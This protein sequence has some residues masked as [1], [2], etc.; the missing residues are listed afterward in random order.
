MNEPTL[1]D[2]PA[3]VGEI[4]AGRAAKVKREINKLIQGVNT[5]TFDL[6][7]LLFEAKSKHYFSDWGFESF[8]KYAKSLD[9]KYTKSYYLVKIIEL[10]K[11]CDIAREQYETVGLVKL[12]AISKL[13]LEGEFNGIPMPMVI[14]ELTLKSPQMTSEEVKLEVDKILGLTED[15]SMVWINFHIKKSARDNVVKAALNLI[16][17]HIP[18]TEDADGVKKDA[19]DG[20]ALELMAANI[21]ADPN[22]NPTEEEADEPSTPESNDEV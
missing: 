5:N 7:N 1:I 19:S 12:R 3:I 18:Q 22:F 21:L 20:A 16:K 15:E 10:M 14:R 8:S 2:P 9:I 17:K 11:G 13:N 6:A 4:E